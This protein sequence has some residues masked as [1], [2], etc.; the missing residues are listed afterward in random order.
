MQNACLLKVASYLGL[1]PKNF[2]P[3]EQILKAY[4][5]SKRE[6]IEIIS[7]DVFISQA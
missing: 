2:T 6:V 1:R 5:N 4:D 3:T 7:I